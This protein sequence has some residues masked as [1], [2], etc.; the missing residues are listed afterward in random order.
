VKNKELIMPCYDGSGPS[1]N[2]NSYEMQKMKERNDLLARVACRALTELEDNGIADMLLLRDDET[3]DFW[4]KHKEF[5]AKRKAAEAEKRRK[6]R[7]KKEALAKLTPE[8]QEALGIKVKKPV[9][10][11]ARSTPAGQKIDAIIAE[12]AKRLND[13][14]DKD[15]WPFLTSD[16]LLGKN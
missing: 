12:M 11:P 13:D 8:E 6:A 2:D 16:Q 3:R 7:I 15:S 14:E 9:S 1:Y 10:R 5:D 4:V